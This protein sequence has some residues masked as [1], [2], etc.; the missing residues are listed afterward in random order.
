MVFHLLSTFICMAGS[1][2]FHWFGCRSPR[3]YRLLRRVDMSSVNVAMIGSFLPI[4]YYMFYCHDVLSVLYSTVQVSSFL[5]LQTF[6]LQ[7]WFYRPESLKMRTNIF[8]MFGFYTAAP[9]A[10]GFLAS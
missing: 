8:V 6:F 7:D 4:A 9:C 5:I 10:H 3:V 2:C 1:F